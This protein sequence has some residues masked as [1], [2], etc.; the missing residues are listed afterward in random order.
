MQTD[1]QP[2]ITDSWDE[3]LMDMTFNWDRRSYYTAALVKLFLERVGFKK[4]KQ[5]NFG[6]SDYDYAFD[7]RQLPDNT[8]IE[9]QKV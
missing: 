7:S 3:F 6:K 2:L 5:K 9:A 4:I 8:Y 1:M